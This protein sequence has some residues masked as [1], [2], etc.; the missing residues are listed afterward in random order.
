MPEA[1]LGG[2]VLSKGEGSGPGRT[3]APHSGQER[4]SWKFPWRPV[5]PLGPVSCIFG[6]LEGGKL[7]EALRMVPERCGP[8]SAAVPGTC[9]WPWALEGA[10]RVPAWAVTARVGIELCQQLPSRTHL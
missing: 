1:F 9:G 7:W 8:S 10:V 3:L 2:G 4:S 6:W 5:M